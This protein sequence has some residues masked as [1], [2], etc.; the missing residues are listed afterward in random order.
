MRVAEFL[1]HVESTS[2][3]P[4][5]LFKGEADL[6]MEE[7]WKKLLD[8]IVPAKARRFNGER[9][10][11]KEHSAAVVIEKLN[12]LPMFGT[13]RLVMVQGIEAWA[14]EGQNAMLSYLEKPHSTACLVLTSSQKKGIE[15]LEAAVAA[16]GIVVV[17]AA[18]TEREAP[19]WLQERARLQNKN[20]SLQAA[21]LLLDQVGLDLQ[22]LERELEKLAAYVGDRQRIE[23]EDVRE[24]VSGQRSFSIFELTNYI[25]RRQR[26]LAVRSL[27]N[28]MR[29]GEAPLALIGL[30]SRQFRI[31]WQIKDGIEKGV[32]LSE[33]NRHL[34]LPQFVLTNYVK[35][36]ASYSETQLQEIHKA[37]R[38]ADLNLKSSGTNPELIMENLILRIS[39]QPDR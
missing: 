18:P 4:V 30:L 36:S 3:A 5:Y 39:E 21:S 12:S 14:K 9:L 13:R 23:L 10:G 20:L 15:R 16:V 24:G 29:A 6:T 37:M 31:I 7:A 34:R 35:E 26:S 11:A 1:R 8:K 28:L 22:R 27:R 32:P 33:L 19:R 2:V 38:E 17:F 25:S